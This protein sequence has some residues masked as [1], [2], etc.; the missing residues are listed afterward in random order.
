MDRRAILVAALLAGV[1]L[2]TGAA[3]TRETRAV[4]AFNGI[5]LAAPVKMEVRQGAAPELVLEGDPSYLAQLVSSVEGGVLT[6]RVKP[7]LTMPWL[8]TVRAYV[9]ATDI[10]VLAVSG[11]GS[12]RSAALQSPRLRLSVSG[13]GDVGIDKLSSTEVH[14]VVSGSG[15]VSLGGATDKV[16][17]SI[18]G[19]GNF[20]AAGLESREARVSVA[21]S[22]DASVWA[23]DSLAVNIAGSGDVSYRGNPKVEK[24]IAGSGSVRRAS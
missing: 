3:S 14:V 2:A 15:D 21:G 20:K 12:I 19:S 11:S 23:R 17:A 18:H 9:T 6:L 8:S 4:G 10:G 16:A 1:A 5:A 13:S 7:G 24:S 22:G